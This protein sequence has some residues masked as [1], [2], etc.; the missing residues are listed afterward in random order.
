MI[1]EA[2]TVG[3]LIREELK[4]RGRTQRWLA[5]RCGVSERH[6]SWL[7]TGQSGLTIEMALKLEALLEVPAL[8]LLVADVEWKLQKAREQGGSG[9]GTRLNN[10]RT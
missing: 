1:A 9:R 2:G 7:M 5:E 4:A 8:A 3:R 10:R 6:M